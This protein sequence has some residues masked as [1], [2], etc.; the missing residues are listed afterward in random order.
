[1]YR[2]VIKEADGIPDMASASDVSWIIAYSRP[3]PDRHRV[4][5]LCLLTTTE[6]Q[7]FILFSVV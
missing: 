6:N 2:Y 1:M 4:L 3:G 7:P 5:T